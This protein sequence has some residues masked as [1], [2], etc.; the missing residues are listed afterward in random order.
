MKTFRLRGVT[1]ESAEV[2][3]LWELGCQ[4][5]HEGVDERGEPVVV[6]YFAAE[7][8]TGI[9]GE[10]EDLPDVDY[11][12]EYRAGLEAVRAGSL[13]VAPG[14]RAVELADGD[15]VV[16]LD[17]GSA[18][19]TGHHETTF[20]ALEA[21]AREDVAG[22]SVLDVGSGSGLLAIAADALGADAA[23]GVDVDPA[24]V[25]VARANAI[26]N[27]SRARFA[28]GTLRVPGGG[29][30]VANPEASDGLGDSGSFGPARGLP[31][32]FDVLVANLYAELHVALMPAYAAALLP[33]GRAH[34]TGILTR[35]AHGVKEAAAAGGLAVKEEREA[36]EWTLLTLEAP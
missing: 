19:G 11:L 26:R 8:D 18:F 3:R 32:R 35:L 1:G 12:A 21:L 24:A 9:P 33:H 15:T 34:L 5:V 20:M 23:Y 28:V 16:W 25:D 30:V 6:A 27:R 14:H 22:R 13:V 17:P 7:V 31:G 36:G 2:A 10:W 4:G 29:R